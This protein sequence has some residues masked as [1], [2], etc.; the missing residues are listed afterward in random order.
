[1]LIKKWIMAL[2]LCVSLFGLV[3]I[4]G[5][6]EPEPSPICSASTYCSGPCYAIG[7]RTSC[8]SAALWATCIAWDESGQMIQYTYLMCPI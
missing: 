3:G 5:N 4:S 1:M 2:F 6:Q 8:T 7:Y